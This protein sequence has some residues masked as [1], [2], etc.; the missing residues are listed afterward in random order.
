MKV[1]CVLYDV[2]KRI[3]YFDVPNFKTSCG[4]N[5]LL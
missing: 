5:V 4:V 3:N 1:Y 2:Y